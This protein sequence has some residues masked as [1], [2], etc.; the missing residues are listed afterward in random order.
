M[1]VVHASVFSILQKFPGHRGRI[2]RL[3][4]ER[5]DF[6]TMCEDYE[7][8]L[9]SLRH[10]STSEAEEATARR[11]EYTAIRLDLEAEI[12]QHLDKPE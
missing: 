10:W 9:M 7:K 5:E 3:Y 6:R 2:M 11:E 1:T 4:R 8:C 12:S